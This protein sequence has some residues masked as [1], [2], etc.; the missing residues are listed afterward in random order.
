MTDIRLTVSKATN[1]QSYVLC[2]SLHERGGKWQCCQI[3]TVQCSCYNE[4]IMIQSLK[5]LMKSSS[6]CSFVF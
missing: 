4:C 2:K 6:L 3:N 5:V 1:F